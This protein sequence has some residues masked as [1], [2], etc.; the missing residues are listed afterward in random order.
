MRTCRLVIPASFFLLRDAIS[1]GS[2]AMIRKRGTSLQVQVYAGRDPL[3]GRKKWVSRQVSGQTRESWRE[4]RKVEGQLLDEVGGGRHKN[5]R[6]MTMRELLLDEWLPWRKANGKAI[7]PTTLRTYKRLIETKILPALGAAPLTAVDARTLDR[8]Y[9]A[10]RNSGNA[11]TGGELSASRVRDVHA[12]LSGALG[13]AAR[14]T[15]LPYNPALLAQPPAPRNARQ[16]PPTS[17]EARLL[18][19]EAAG[20]DP[21]LYLFLRLSA[22]GGLRR[23]EVCALRPYDL[24]L[25]EAEVTVTGNIVF[26]KGLPEGFIR[27]SPK[28]ENSE[29]LLALDART[30]ELLRDYLARRDAAIRAA[31][32]AGLRPDAYIFAQD[33]AGTRPVH[34]DTMT[35]RCKRLAQRLGYPYT[36]KSLRHFMATQLGAVAQAGTV[37]ERMGHGSLQVTSIYTHRVSE[38]DRAAAAHMGRLLDREFSPDGAGGASSS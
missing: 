7:S 5:A 28:S 10:L 30:V 2:L 18:L 15:W 26:E 27:K 35:G 24:D 16:K 23:G 9:A 20:Q 21:E 8:F 29:R 4:A 37:R 38:A 36:L 1:K 22:V 31:G 25:D 34:P 19:E 12:I 17:E 3:T 32:G 11:R 33:L 6:K 13:L 14:Y